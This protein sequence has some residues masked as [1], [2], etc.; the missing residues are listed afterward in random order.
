MSDRDKR[1][2]QMTVLALVAWGIL[3]QFVGKRFDG[4]ARAAEQTRTSLRSDIQKYLAIG[5]TS[6]PDYEKQLRSH[7]G[8]CQADREMLEKKMGYRI[9][10]AYAPP[11]GEAMPSLAVLR[12]RVQLSERIGRDAKSPS[13]QTSRGPMDVS[14][15]TSVKDTFGIPE[16]LPAEADR[17]ATYSLQLGVVAKAWEKI[18]E[19]NDRSRFQSIYAVD[20]LRIVPTRNFP[21]RGDHIFGRKLPVRLS[22]RLNLRALMAFL[23]ALDE[24]GRALTLEAVTVHPPEDPTLPLWV[25]M[26]LSAISLEGVRAAVVPKKAYSEPR[27]N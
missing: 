9:D 20:E 15:V 25:T 21:D 14:S 8:D 6:F 19:V 4:A 18:L 11:T 23:D 22:M 26:E 13:E 16:A 7:L 12:R 3:V 5:G 24:P 10:P 1:L 2:V 17:L 27:G